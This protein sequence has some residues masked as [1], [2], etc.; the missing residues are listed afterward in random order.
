MKPNEESLNLE[1]SLPSTGEKV[2]IPITNGDLFFEL[3]SRHHSPVEGTNNKQV[4]SNW[5]KRNILKKMCNDEC[6]KTQKIMPLILK[7]MGLSKEEISKKMKEHTLI[8]SKCFSRTIKSL[9][10][11]QL[12]FLE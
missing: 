9:K 12:H 3:Y 6:K 5:V 1:K 7:K 11:F 2:S 8:G 4:I 10:Y